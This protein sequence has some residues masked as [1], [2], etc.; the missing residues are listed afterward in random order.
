MIAYVVFTKANQDSWIFRRLHKDIS[1]CYIMFNQL[2]KWFVLDH[3]VNKLDVYTISDYSDI[4]SESLI[5]KVNTIEA[6]SYF[7]LNTCV[8]YVKRFI[9]LKDIRV[10][11]PYQL[12]KR[13]ASCQ[14]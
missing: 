4:L 7:G 3:S 5:V 14:V 9:G 2:D 12:F 1:H 6:V 11:T 13:L 8:S 10:Q